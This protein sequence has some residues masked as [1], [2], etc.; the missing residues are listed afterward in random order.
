MNNIQNLTTRTNTTKSQCNF[1][2]VAVAVQL[3][4]RKVAIEA[5]TFK[6]MGVVPLEAKWSRDIADIVGW[7]KDQ[8][9]VKWNVVARVK[10]MWTVSNNIYLLL[11]AG[12]RKGDWNVWT[13]TIS[14]SFY[15]LSFFLPTIVRIGFVFDRALLR[16]MTLNNIFT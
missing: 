14:D 10:G 8:F 16:E 9:R 1:A 5:N 11:V 3:I 13:N 6:S 12:L 7:N 2:S 4:L 15:D